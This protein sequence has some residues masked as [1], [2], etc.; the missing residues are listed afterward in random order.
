[1]VIR[2]WP[3][4]RILSNQGRCDHIVR[5]IQ[6]LVD[7]AFDLLDG[8]SCGAELLPVAGRVR[9]PTRRP[10]TLADMTSFG[11]YELGSQIGAGGF[12]DVYLAR[13]V[14][15]S[16]TWALK[17]LHE[18]DPQAITELKHEARTLWNLPIPGVLTPTE[19][20]QVDQRWFMAM[21]LGTGQSLRAALEDGPLAPERAREILAALAQ[22]L[23]RLHARGLLH[24]DIKPDNVLVDELN[25][26]TLL[27]FGL[28]R[29]DRQGPA[30]TLGA[31]PTV[32][33]SW[34]YAAP[35]LIWGEQPTAASDAYALGAL[36]LELLTASPPNPALHEQPLAELAELGPVGLVCAAL[37]QREAALRWSAERVAEVLGGHAIDV[38][39]GQADAMFGRERE[40][41]RLEQHRRATLADAESRLLFV[42]G[43]PGIGKTICIQH[44]LDAL[45]ERGTRCVR[46]HC[47]EIVRSLAEGATIS[48]ALRAKVAVMFPD[49]GE[50]GVPAEVGAL[51]SLREAFV[52]FVDACVADEPLVIWIDDVQWL[53]LDGVVLLTKLL[54]SSRAALSI[55]AS[56]R[57]EHLEAVLAKLGARP[58]SSRIE[59]L[60]LTPLEDAA[61]DELLVYRG[62]RDAELRAQLIAQAGGNPF[63]LARVAEVAELSPRPSWDI[64]TALQHQLLSLSPTQRAGV[65]LL[66][67]AGRALSNTVL[68]AALQRMH[69]GDPIAAL[70]VRGWLRSAS[71]PTNG[72]AL[73]HGLIGAHALAHMRNEDLRGCH[74]ALLEAL[75]DQG[76]PASE[77]F[78]HALGV[79]AQVRA[80]SLA[81]A[82][83]QAADARAAFENASEWFARAHELGAPEWNAAQAVDVLRATALD[84]AGRPRDAAQWYVRSL[85]RVRDP[86]QRWDLSLACAEAWMT[87]GVLE[88]GRSVLEPV[89]REHGIPLERGP[90]RLLSSI[91]AQLL[92]LR[93]P[94]PR[95]GAIDEAALRR[96]D[97]CWTLAKGLAYT[98]PAEALDYALRSLAAARRARDPRAQARALAFLGGGVF[99]QVPGMS[100]L[101]QRYMASARA[102]ADASAPGE[103]RANIELWQG[104]IDIGRGRWIDARAELERALE[105]LERARKSRWDRSTAGQFLIWL[106]WRE[107][108]LHAMHE[109]ARVEQALAHERGDRLTWV[110]FSHFVAFWQL[111]QGRPD[112]ALA[113]A[114]Q[115]R[116]LW[117]PLNFSVQSFYTMQIEVEGLL[118][119]GELARARAT[120]AAIQ[121]AFRRAGGERAAVSRIDNAMLRARLALHEGGASSLT[122]LRRIAAALS[123]ELRPDA[124]AHGAWLAAVSR[125]DRAGLHE[126]SE[127]LAAARCSLASLALALQLDDSSETAAAMRAR[128]VAQ[129]QRWAGVYYPITVG[130]AAM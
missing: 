97:L 59:I 94:T 75:E 81:L 104:V 74:G 16:T 47:D 54:D 78:E 4:S 76:A 31:R 49:L 73:Y 113:L 58:A 129:P 72:V 34:A 6:K 90:V 57:S 32:G 7:L 99:F 123:R 91:L 5:P 48:P 45:A 83:G 51:A 67:V 28:A 55:V 43:P 116:T 77:L 124:A 21:E 111:A 128:G 60:E 112:R 117:S 126:A 15:D 53:D 44:W 62:L 107:G 12:G 42:G 115:I 85:E 71:A 70:K 125:G 29:W 103:L 1:L 120:W 9:S 106:D 121:A 23:A 102:L 92:S 18:R 110:V 3:L 19:V 35:E 79:G 24:L 80:A 11:G 114:E 36:G 95:L 66:A 105:L 108:D 2:A 40:L 82:A 61:A 68:L 26:V 56:V 33:L 14:T 65:E 39:P 98:K 86:D 69:D 30:G 10:Y 130:P 96:A 109:R 25:Q 37:L 88:H 38:G 118:Y 89:L 27:D 46:G 63:V 100:G 13:R 127:Q 84:N 87:S 8:R 22:I 101:A 119:L 122:E 64:D 50:P 93:R 52:E 20:G 41:E 17:I